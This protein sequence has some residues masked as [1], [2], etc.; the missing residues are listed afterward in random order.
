MKRQKKTVAKESTE[1]APAHPLRLDVETDEA[2]RERATKT[3][4]SVAQTLRR[5]IRAGLQAEKQ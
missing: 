2:V 4:R 5:L 3:E 1:W